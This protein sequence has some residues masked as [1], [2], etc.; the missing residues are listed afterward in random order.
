MPK[1]PVTLYKKL[2]L[3][4]YVAELGLNITT[5]KELTYSEQLML[6]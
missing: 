6:L 5:I 1:A 2:V 4:D 3:L